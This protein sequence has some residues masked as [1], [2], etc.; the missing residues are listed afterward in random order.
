MN[1]RLFFS[2]LLVLTN[3]IL[4]SKQIDQKEAKQIAENFISNYVSYQQRNAGFD[5]DLVY[6]GFNQDIKNKKGQVEK[7]YYVYNI[8]NK[9]GFIIISADDINYPIIGYSKTGSYDVNHLPENFKSWMKSVEMGMQHAFDNS[10]NPTQEIKS[11]WEAYRSSA[12]NIRARFTEIQ[13]LIK[14]KW[15]QGAPYNSQIPYRVYTGCVAT[16]IAQIMKFHQYPISGIGKIPA[17]KTV[18]PSNN[19]TYNL[20]EIDL[21]QYT[22]QWSDMLNDYSIG[23]TPEQA[24]AVG[25]LMYHIGASVKMQYGINGSGAYN[26]DALQSLYT[27]FNYD[28]GIDYVIRGKYYSNVS[29][30]IINDDEWNSLIVNELN[31][32]RPI[33]Y[34][35][36]TDTKAGHAFVCDGYDSNGLFHFNFGWSGYMNGY[37]NSN[38]PLNYKYTQSIGLNIKPN[39]GGEKVARYFVDKFTISKNKVY[40]EECFF[41]S[42]TIFNISIGNTIDYNKLY[43]ALCDLNGNIVTI[44]NEGNNLTNYNKNYYSIGS[45]IPSGKYR[46]KIVEK[47]GDNYNC[48]KTSKSVEANNIIEVLDGV[49]SHNLSLL[50]N[51]PF[52]TD[53]SQ[54]D[55]NDNLYL[56]FSFGNSGCENFTGNIAIVLTDENDSLKYILGQKTINLRASY[57]YSIYSVNVHFP[58]EVPSGTY[59]VRIFAR[60]NENQTWQVLE[61]AQI[62]YVSITFTNSNELSSEILNGVDKISI[63]PNPV[64]DV[65]HLKTQSDLKVKSII[66]Y[67]FSGKEVIN[68]SLSSNEINVSD[69]KSGPYVIKIQTSNGDKKYRFI[70]K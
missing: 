12:K 27:Y 11:E 64:Q 3:L 34:S 35:G 24:K 14:T 16:A 44:L 1:K 25:L 2:L 21:T 5:L 22:Y 39:E 8:G 9:Q 48:I 47:N 13:P 37:Y 51:T 19:E 60:K 32:G 18:D 70:K 67:D 23:Y 56:K 59:R 52:S 38:A 55:I 49:K 54:V 42:Q 15:D 63:Y 40:K 30:I 57:Y 58:S 61:G 68:E 62:N 31:N 17:Y 45:N 41:E 50:D 26:E 36:Y 53:K 28:Q 10:I 43:L 46:L 6:T 7:Y 4:W 29:E 33:Y 20:P 65:L 69:L 66:I